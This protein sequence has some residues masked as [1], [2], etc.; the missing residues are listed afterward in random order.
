VTLR[1]AYYCAQAALSKLRETSGGLILMTSPAGMEG[2]R[3]LA[4]YGVVKGALRGFAK[5]LAR[6]AFAELL[7]CCL[8]GKNTGRCACPLLPRQ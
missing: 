2:S 3:M 1:A 8:C 7:L 6:D 4:A 5:S